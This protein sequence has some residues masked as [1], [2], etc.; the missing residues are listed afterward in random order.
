MRLRW[1]SIDVDQSDCRPIRKR[2][3]RVMDIMENF[4]CIKLIQKALSWRAGRET[5]A[6]AVLEKVR[7]TLRSETYF[8]A[9]S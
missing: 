8:S 1:K 2:T 9:F 5:L 6:R 3:V 7:A 4:G